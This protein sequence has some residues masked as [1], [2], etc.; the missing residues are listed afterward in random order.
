MGLDMGFVGKNRQTAM[1]IFGSFRPSG[2][3][4]AFGR[5]W[6]FFVGLK[7]HA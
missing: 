7:P 1:A 6:L 3:T 5:A 4:P 2:C